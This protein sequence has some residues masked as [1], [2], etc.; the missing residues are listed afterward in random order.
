VDLEA[1]PRLLSRR[2]LL[3]V[4]SAA[5]VGL[6]LGG[7]STVPRIAHAAP[8]SFGVGPF[9]RAL[10]RLSDNGYSLRSAALALNE[11]GSVL[12]DGT[13]RTRRVLYNYADRVGPWVDSLGD[14]AHDRA[15]GRQVR[16]DRLLRV[17]RA[18]HVYRAPVLLPSFYG[19]P[20]VFQVGEAFGFGLLPVGFPNPGLGRLWPAPGDF[21]GLAY[22]LGPQDVPVVWFIASTAEYRGIG[23]VSAA[24][25]VQTE[26][27]AYNSGQADW[28]GYQASDA[29]LCSCLRRGTEESFDFPSDL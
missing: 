21:W 7:L 13:E 27:V 23:P 1:S 5:G 16:Y 14:V 17:R 19:L 24:R 29:V 22:A 3:Q 6:A 10:E 11:G 9:D 20:R 28:M 26:V 25:A 4:G 2:R 15:R 18:L 8:I 12:V